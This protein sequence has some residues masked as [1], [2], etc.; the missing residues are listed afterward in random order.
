MRKTN[1]FTLIE[2]MIV[3]AIIGILAAIAI[4]NFVR[5]QLRTKLGELRENVG[6]VFKSQEAVRQSERAIGTPPMTGLY[7]ALDF[8]PG[9]TACTPATTK[10][11]WRASDVAAAGLVD[12]VV[13]GNTYGCYKVGAGTGYARGTRGSGLVVEAFSDIDGDGANAC[14]YLY[15]PVLDS[16]GRAVTTTAPA[17]DGACAVAPQA[18]P[19][20]QATQLTGDTVF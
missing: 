5:Y 13:E 7:Y 8:L 2:L 3:V 17:F 9:D 4:P 12:W 18:P 6:S 11:A 10:Q 19:Y 14:V 1:G 16:A 20:G 15:K